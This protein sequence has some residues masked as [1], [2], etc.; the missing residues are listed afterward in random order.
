V[1]PLPAQASQQLCAAPMHAVPSRG[2]RQAFAARAILHRVRP[3]ALVRQHDTAP[4]RPQI[5]FAAHRT[6]TFTQPGLESAVRAVALAQRLCSE[7]DGAESHG[8]LIPTVMRAAA[9]SVAS[10]PVGSQ[11]AR[12]GRPVDA[13]A[14]TSSTPIHVARIRPP[15]VRRTYHTPRNDLHSFS[16]R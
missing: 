9:T 10:T 11:A 8:Q 4:G 7:A 1:Q 15:F 3:L 2:G 5:E 6:T 16:W 14:K 12:P 13:S